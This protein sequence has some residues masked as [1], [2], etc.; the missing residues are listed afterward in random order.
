MMSIGGSSG[1]CG[2][3]NMIADGAVVNRSFRL[4]TVVVGR[5]WLTGKQAFAP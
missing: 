3:K 1:I 2:L 5:A 4:S